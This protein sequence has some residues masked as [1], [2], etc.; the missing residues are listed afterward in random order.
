MEKGIQEA[1]PRQCS[2]YVGEQA[3]TSKN[4]WKGQTIGDSQP[5]K[6]NP[7][8]TKSSKREKEWPR[9]LSTEGNETVP[10]S[11]KGRDREV[12]KARLP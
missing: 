10:K 2:L 12:N 8:M 11:G 7:T 4:C 5:L 6:N 1:R 3:R 9:Q